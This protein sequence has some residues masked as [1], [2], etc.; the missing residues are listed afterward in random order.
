MREYFIPR[1]INGVVARAESKGDIASLAT[2]WAHVVVGVVGV[3]AR[4]KREVH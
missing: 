3:G 1:L 4:R 2:V